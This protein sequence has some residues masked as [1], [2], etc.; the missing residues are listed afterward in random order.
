MPNTFL[1]M[2]GMWI[3]TPNPNPLCSTI[4]PALPTERTTLLIEGNARNWLYTTNLILEEH[5]LESIDWVLEELKTNITGDWEKL[6]DT[7]CRWAIRRYGKRLNRDTLN[8]AQAELAISL[9]DHTRRD[10][11]SN[12]VTEVTTERFS[13]EDFQKLYL[14]SI[15]LS[16]RPIMSGKREIPL[17]SA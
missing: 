2:S 10:D 4:N 15:I 11:R 7:A 12:D 6:F 9:G 17:R 1:T 16:V 14:S 13:E 3:F 8:Q 5:Y